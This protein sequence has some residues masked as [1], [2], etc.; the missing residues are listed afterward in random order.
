MATSLTDL[1]NMALDLLGVGQITTLGTDG[2]AQDGF[3]NRNHLRLIKAVQRQHPFNRI[4]T[5]KVLDYVPGTL[6]LSST[7]VGTGVTA[8]SSVAFFTE[9]DVGALLKELGTGATGVAEIT[10]YTSPTVVTVE[11][12]TAWNGTSPIAQNSWHLKPQGNDF[13]YG[14]VLPSDLLLFNHLD[15]E[16]AQWAIEGDRVLTT[17]SDA[18]AHYA[19]YLATPDDWDQLLLDAIVAKLAAE[20]AWPLTKNQKLQADMQNLYGRKVAE[21]MG[22]SDSEKQRQTKYAAT[23]LKDV[24]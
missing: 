19:R 21:A 5:R 14:Y 8:T 15:D 3:M 9:R 13:A 18:V 7:A 11:N 16:E 1:V 6:T 10:A 17:Y 24:R 4:V 23:V 20:A 22:V 12:T 2:T